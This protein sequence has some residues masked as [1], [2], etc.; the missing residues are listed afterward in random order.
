MSG[1]G[2]G[3]GNRTYPRHEEHLF[4]T[5]SYGKMPEPRAIIVRKTPS[6]QPKPANAAIGDERRGSLHDI[7]SCPVQHDAAGRERR[8]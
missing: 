3:D 2:A 6:Y 8:L 5:M 1:S 7:A 4:E